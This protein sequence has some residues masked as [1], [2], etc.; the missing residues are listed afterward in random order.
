MNYKF[1]GK[2]AAGKWVYGYY[3]ANDKY[4]K[5]FIIEE[6]FDCQEYACVGGRN[7]AQVLPETVGQWTGLKDKNGIEGFCGDLVKHKDGTIYQIVFNAELASF[8]LK[9][10]FGKSCCFNSFDRINPLLK[11]EIIGNIHDNPELLEG[12]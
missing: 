1:R 8:C 10:S 9:F 11:Y 12:K 5:H 3:G 2:T 7:Y 4:G 6:I